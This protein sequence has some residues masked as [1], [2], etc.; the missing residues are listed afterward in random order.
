MDYKKAWT[1][2]NTLAGAA[3]F[4]VMLGGY[5]AHKSEVLF[6]GIVGAA[7]VMGVVS[8]VLHF[9]WCRCPGCGDR[10]RVTDWL[11]RL[12]AKCPK[13]GEKLR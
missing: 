10:I 8:F 2:S 4:T 12:P 5:F 1:Y 3:V 11:M 13:C 9:K 6:W 7:L